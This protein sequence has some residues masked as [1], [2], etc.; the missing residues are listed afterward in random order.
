MGEPVTPVGD[1]DSILLGP[2]E[3]LWGMVSESV[4]CR[5]EGDITNGFCSPWG[6]KQALVG[7]GGQEPSL[8]T[9][10]ELVTSARAGVQGQAERK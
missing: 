7:W 5:L 10:A 2:S 1:W 9:W 3:E 4:L 8:S 6:R